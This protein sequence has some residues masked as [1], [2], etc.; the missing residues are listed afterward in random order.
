MDFI[1]LLP[2]SGYYCIASGRTMP[3]EGTSWVHDRL[4]ISPT[5]ANLEAS[6]GVQTWYAI[7]SY[8]HPGAVGTSKTGRCVEN[9][10]AL[11]TLVWDIDVDP[12]KGGYGTADAAV[13]ALGRY[14]ASGQLLPPSAVVASGGGL[15][16]Y[17]G[18][19]NEIDTDGWRALELRL[20]ELGRSVD[21]A[22]AI[23]PSC[24]KNPAG[25]L[26]WP[27]STNSKYTPARRVEILFLHRLYDYA[28][29]DAWLP[30]T[31]SNVVPLRAHHAPVTSLVPT[32][33]PVVAIPRTQTD[34]GMV[35]QHCGAVRYYASI[36]DQ[37]SYP[38]WWPI[39]QLTAFMDDGR[40]HAHELSQGHPA[41]NPAAVDAK[42]AEASR[43]AD[44]GSGPYSCERLCADLGVNRAVA[45]AGC[46]L[47]SQTGST[48][49]PIKLPALIASAQS[50]PQPHAVQYSDTTPFEDL[51][52]AVVARSPVYTDIAVE[53]PNLLL[54]TNGR[55]T[56]SSDGAL[57]GAV[58]EEVQQVQF[59]PMTG[60]EEQ[61]TTRMSRNVI[62]SDQAFWPVR[63]VAETSGVIRLEFAAIS[64]KFKNGDFNVSLHIS[65]QEPLGNLSRLH[66]HLRQWNVHCR[67]DRAAV[68]LLQEYLHWIGQWS[69]RPAVRPYQ[70]FGWVERDLFVVGGIG[71]TKT[72]FEPVAVAGDAAVV[73]EKGYV[74]HAGSLAAQV[75]ILREIAEAGTPIARFIMMVPFASVLYHM[76]GENPMIVH[77]RGKSGLGKSFIMRLAAS[78]FGAPYEAHITATDTAKAAENIMSALGDMVTMFDEVTLIGEERLQ[79]L[80]MTVSK[81]TSNSARASNGT[82][83]LRADVRTWRG[84]VVTSGN[85]SLHEAALND[86][87]LDKAGALMAR[88]AELAVDEGMLETVDGGES[89]A[90]RAIR[91]RNMADEN[92]GLLGLQ[93]IS[94]CVRNRAEVAKR[95]KSLVG[96]N[97][98]A[99][100]TGSA[101]FFDALAAS[102]Q[103]AEEILHQ[104]G[105][106]PMTNR[107]NSFANIISALQTK[108]VATQREFARSSLEPIMAMRAEWNDGFE[109]RLDGKLAGIPSRGLTGIESRTTGQPFVEIY[110]TTAVFDSYTHR[111]KIQGPALLAQLAREGYVIP[112]NT[113]VYQHNLV[114][115]GMASGTAM[116]GFRIPIA[117]P[118]SASGTPP[119]LAIV[120]P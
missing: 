37:A 26:R 66:Q 39:I 67:F 107:T 50:G 17:W 100:N 85:V 36:K 2:A 75:Q 89:G 57:C 93:F 14:I 3:N 99:S 117:A 23:D 90:A 22:L 40:R 69:A 21:P 58:I 92:Y 13:E 81:G 114:F 42:Y 24:F 84:L 111:C 73:V 63:L 112:G 38:Q 101:R 95:V 104:M 51:I 72:G 32:Q 98:L 96:A 53:V 87:N 83:N 82:G 29:I 41:Y 19:T 110:I 103:A 115:S 12:S 28:E 6:R 71:V 74:K 11:K 25:V 76:T 35:R 61:V 54:M 9:I 106:W 8:R 70:R 49:N 118:V 48:A 97:K 30:A 65:P 33:S 105:Y 16:C 1:D 79:A 119:A 120:R 113:G 56:I 60:R 4:Q 108:T 102:M 91:L 18:L 116:Y 80:S 109:V 44:G 55:F 34:G 10:I 45:C 43:V 68:R 20:L 62:I 15:H 5:I 7:A 47:A 78:M 86:R 59:N 27:G 77:L 64:G 52:R 46:P 88:V 31:G 94:H